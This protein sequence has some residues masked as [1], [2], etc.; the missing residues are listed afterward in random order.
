[1]RR[2]S[3]FRLQSELRSDFPIRRWFLVVL[4]TF[5]IGSFAGCG[6]GGGPYPAEGIAYFRDGTRL[7]G[8]TVEAQ[9]VFSGGEKFIAKGTI[10][11]DGTFRLSMPGRGDGAMGG[12]HRV[13][14]LPP[15]PSS[16]R[17]TAVA[18]SPHAIHPRM[19]SFDTSGLEF[20]VHPDKGPNKLIVEV[21]FDQERD[22]K[23]GRK[24]GKATR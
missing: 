17:S 16:G 24:T 4:T 10:Q 11:P 2:I 15:E 19:Q 7:T 3:D 12:L 8:G 5:T 13:R 1:M 23:E 20:Y 6:W 14:V 21:M 18:P 22:R 9:P